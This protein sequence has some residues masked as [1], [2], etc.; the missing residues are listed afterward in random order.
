M[1]EL[2][3][4]ALFCVPF[5]QLVNPRNFSLLSL[6]NLSADLEVVIAARN[7]YMLISWMVNTWSHELHNWIITWFYTLELKCIVWQCV[8]Y[9]WS[10]NGVLKFCKFC[11]VFVICRKVRAVLMTKI[12][13]FWLFSVL[14]HQSWIKF[15]FCRWTG[16]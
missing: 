2:K 5:D 10:L 9:F 13:W 6:K 8:S 14:S 1:V 7:R 15:S 16:H 12:L 11:N 3:L 4:E